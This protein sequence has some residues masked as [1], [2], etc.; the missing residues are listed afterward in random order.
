VVDIND[1]QFG[2]IRPS[3]VPWTRRANDG[4]LYVL[5][6]SSGW[7]KVGR[8]AATRSDDARIVQV[9]RIYREVRGWEI[10]NSWVSEVPL[11]TVRRAGQRSADLDDAEARVKRHA[12][13]LGRRLSEVDPMGCTGETEVFYGPAFSYLRAYADVISRC[14]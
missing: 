1:V 6:F 13:D 12:A 8:T 5:E 11:S 7:V 3:E 10:T 14:T 9:G 4:V 2:E